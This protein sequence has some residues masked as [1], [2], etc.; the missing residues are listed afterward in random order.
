[1]LFL[2]WSIFISHFISCNV[3]NVNSVKNTISIHRHCLFIIRIKSL[4][5]T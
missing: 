4:K 5:N 1:V 2:G 3:T